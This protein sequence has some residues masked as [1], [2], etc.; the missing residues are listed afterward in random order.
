M[1]DER[2]TT[3]AD[4]DRRPTDV[5]AQGGRLFFWQLRS[6]GSAFCTALPLRSQRISCRI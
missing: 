3:T 2:G 4:D 5:D 6:E 1:N